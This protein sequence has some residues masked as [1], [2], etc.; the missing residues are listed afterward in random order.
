MKACFPDII[1]VVIHFYSLRYAA[2]LK[3]THKI[4]RRILWVPQRRG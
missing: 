3:N 2:R 4:L 1:R